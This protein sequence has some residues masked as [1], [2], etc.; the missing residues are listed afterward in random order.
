M[1]QIIKNEHDYCAYNNFSLP[2]VIEK[3]NGIY[4]YDITGKQ[5]IDCLAAYSVVNQGHCHPR[6]VQTAID[7]LQKCTI[8][9]RAFYNTEYGKFGK[10]M[11]DLFGFE[12]VLCMNTGLEIVETAFKL[13]RKW[14]YLKKNIPENKAIILGCKGNFHGRSISI[15]SLSDNPSCYTGYGPFVPNISYKCPITQKEITLNDLDTLE[16]CFKTHASL[17]AGF[18]IEPVQGEGGINIPEPGFLSNINKLCKK[19][20]ILFICDEIQTGLGRTGKM[21][22]IEHYLG[23]DK[24]D[25]LLLGKSLGGG[26]YPISCLLSTT[27]IVSCI[28]P[29]EH[30]S[31]FACNPLALSIAQTAL[32]IIIDENLVSNSYERGLQFRSGLTDFVKDYKFIKDVRGIGLFNAIEVTDKETAYKFCLILMSNNLLAKSTRDKIIRFTPPLIITKE[33]MDQVIEIIKKSIIEF[34]NYKG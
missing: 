31:T 18:I 12:K 29:G 25:I 6:L 24:P 8:T 34:E 32:D 10:K 5:Y 14:G 1:E 4:M 23:Q 17:I 26:L 20:N 15:V 19:Y 7:Q 28:K 2:C 16:L 13:V 22:A 30:G 21:L 33:Q 27:E 3:A 9:S 11:H